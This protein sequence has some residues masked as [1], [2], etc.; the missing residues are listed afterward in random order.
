MWDI[1]PEEAAELGL[2]DNLPIR[3]NTTTGDN[4]QANVL[5][6]R[7]N[8]TLYV[9]NLPLDVKEPEIRD[10][11]NAVMIAAQVPFPKQHQHTPL[12]QL[13]HFEIF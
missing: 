9:G 5:T 10:F 6:D 12:F 13:F 1:Q 7:Q 4:Y 8:R 2:F 11:F 3:F